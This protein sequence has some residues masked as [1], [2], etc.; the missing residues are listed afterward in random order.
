VKHA[1]ERFDL[2]VL[3][4]V[5]IV[6]LVKLALL[7]VIVDRRPGAFTYVDTWTYV[8]PALALLAH[9]TFSPSPEAAPAPEINRTP[10][11]PLLIAAGFGTL[12]QRPW[13]LPAV[14]ALCAAGTALAAAGLAAGLF[15]RRA[16]LIAGAIVSLEPGTFFRS[17]DALS[18]TPFTLLLTLFWASLATWGFAPS[19]SPWRA[20]VW[21]ALAT[22]VRPL[23]YYLIP[24]AAIAVGF[25][26]RRV[27]PLRGIAGLLI[28]PIALVGGWRARNYVRAGTSAELNPETSKLP[29]TELT[30]RWKAQALEIIKAHPVLTV[31]TV[32][33]SAFL[34][35]LTPSTLIPAAKYG[36]VIPSARLLGLYDDQRPFAFLAAL[37][38]ESPALFVVSAAHI[39]LL[40]AL[41]AAAGVKR[42]ASAVPRWVH[43]VLLATFAYVLAVSSH[44]ASRDERFRLPLIPIAAVYASCALCVPSPGRFSATS[45]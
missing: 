16:G 39:G 31:R 18:D 33:A 19:R 37:A 20:G 6:L 28:A 41:W 2:G 27:K 34:V 11:Y 7:A 45:P 43:A 5:S 24:V 21:L 30:R 26:A 13:V 44:A 25:K 15:G 10:G 22:L 1:H 9:G 36:F 38:R 42:S 8:R 12:G 35:L 29:Y 23:S 17:L 40:L 4:L 32:C 3:S 14:G